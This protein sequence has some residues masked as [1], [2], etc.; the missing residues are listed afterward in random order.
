MSAHVIVD[1]DV[2]DPAGMREYLERV[3]GTPEGVWRPLHCARGKFEIVEGD[4][5]PA[6]GV[7]M[8]F[9]NALV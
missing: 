9:P 4:W 1:I 7:M 2:H 6:R 3:P 8:E 5:L